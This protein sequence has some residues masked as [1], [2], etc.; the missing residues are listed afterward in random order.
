MSALGRF[1]K[2]ISDTSCLIKSEPSQF[3]ASFRKVVGVVAKKIKRTEVEFFS[4]R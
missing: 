1:R 2:L 4:S 3:K